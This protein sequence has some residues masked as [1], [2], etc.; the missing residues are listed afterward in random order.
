MKMT[1]T[2]ARYLISNG[3]FKIVASPE[4][5]T[6]KHHP[7]NKETADKICEALNRS[8]KFHKEVSQLINLWNKKISQE[9]DAPRKDGKLIDFDHVLCA[10]VEVL[11]HIMLKKYSISGNSVENYSHDRFKNI[12]KVSAVKDMFSEVWEEDR[13]A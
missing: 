2:M 13:N 12:E 11:R 10:E 5:I 1:E 6:I 4:K 9:I 8:G 3:E 7:R